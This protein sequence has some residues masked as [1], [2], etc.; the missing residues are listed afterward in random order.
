MRF[1]FIALLL[2]L[3]CV[4]ACLSVGLVEEFS[5][6]R[7]T[8][9]WPEDSQLRARFLGADAAA[10]RGARYRPTKPISKGD[11]A[12]AESP[13]VFEGNTNANVTPKNDTT[14]EIDQNS[15]SNNEVIPSSVDYQY[16]NNIPMGANV[17]KDKLFITIPRRRLGV[18]ST[19]NYVPLNNAERNNV[20]L[21]PYPSWNMNLYPDTSGQLENFV[22]VYRIAIDVCDRMWFVDTGIVETLGNRTQVKP[23]QLI[24][25]NLQTDQVILRFNLP[26]NVITSA[27][28]LAS[29]TV[30]TPKGSCGDAFVYFPD[31]AGYGLIVFSLRDRKAWRVS[32]NYFFLEPMAGD[33]NIAGHNFQWNDG[34]FSV[35]LS[36]MKS[37]GYRDM[38]FHA[39][40]GT[41]MYKV[42]TRVLRNESLATRSFHDDDFV[43]LGDRGPQSQTST[44]DIHKPTGIM[45]LGLVNQNALG[46]WNIKK[47]LKTIDIVQKDDQKMIYP[48]DVKVSGDKVYVLT[49]TMPEFLYGRLN[50]DVTNFRV[51][52]NDV[53]K[54]VQ[55]T[56]CQG[57]R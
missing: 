46:C 22:S 39:M 7:I 32:H 9:Q 24:A 47:S 56:K 44:A 26:E 42:S 17:W 13:I 38:F 14:S 35:E 3:I 43:I 19:L 51:W 52:A 21:I 15:G 6:S 10:P 34:V 27:T 31:L 50:Y 2:C 1:F 20:P 16:I 37:D 8:Y 4:K 23:H 5:W 18:P 25:I 29:L 41:H 28:V 54:A 40:S 33:F 30:D 53:R 48:S 45:F 55:D 12:A 57:G 36:D 49:N 11:G